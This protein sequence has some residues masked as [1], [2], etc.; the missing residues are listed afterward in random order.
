MST[1]KKGLISN[2][3]DLDNSVKLLTDFMKSNPG[4]EPFADADILMPAGNRTLVQ[5]VKFANSLRLRLAIRISNVS[6]TLAASE[7][8][9]ALEQANGLLEN[10]EETVKPLLQ[11]KESIQ[12]HW[13]NWSKLG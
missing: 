9:K 8:K 1:R 2:L 11:P 13:V 6:K 7:T 10:A 3:G 5:W 4:V 12:I